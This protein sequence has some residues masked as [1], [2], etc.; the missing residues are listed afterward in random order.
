MMDRRADEWMGG[1]RRSQYPERFFQKRG[2][3]NK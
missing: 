2:D 1:R 3:N